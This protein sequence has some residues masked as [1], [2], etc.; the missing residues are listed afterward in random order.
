MAFPSKI[1]SWISL[2]LWTPG[3]GKLRDIVIP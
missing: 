2:M 3:L 1:S